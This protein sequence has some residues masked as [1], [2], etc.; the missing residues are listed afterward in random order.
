MIED[1][2]EFWKEHEE[3]IKQIAITKDNYK[4]KIRS[5]QVWSGK[6]QKFDDQAKLAKLFEMGYID[7]YGDPLQNNS[8]E[9]NDIR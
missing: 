3:V 1:D 7:D 6:N 5:I 2:K 4:L 9:N 8:D